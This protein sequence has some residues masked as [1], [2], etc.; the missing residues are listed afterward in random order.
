MR[1]IVMH[2]ILG[3]DGLANIRGSMELGGLLEEVPLGL[4]HWSCKVP[5][6]SCTYFAHNDIVVDIR[7]EHLEDWTICLHTISSV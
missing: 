5:T 4:R 2:D 3:I 7:V 6:M 1:N